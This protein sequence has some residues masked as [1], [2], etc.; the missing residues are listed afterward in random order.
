MLPLRIATHCLSRS[1][2]LTDGVHGGSVAIGVQAR[3][4]GDEQSRE[5]AQG[6][7]QDERAEGALPRQELAAH[8]A[9]CNV[10]MWIDEAALAGISEAEPTRGHPRLYSDA[11]IQALLGIKTVFRLP[12][13]SLQ[14]FAQS[15]R[16]LA[17]SPH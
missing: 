15:R 11:L 10:T 4:R 16:E 6:Q 7:A 13:R 9:G 14:G 17:A 3:G 2:A 8:N 1:C 12:L 5:D